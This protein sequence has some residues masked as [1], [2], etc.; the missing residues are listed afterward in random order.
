V[1]E[2]MREIAAAWGYLPQ[3]AGQQVFVPK[4]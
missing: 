1:P 4:A 3:R 2:S